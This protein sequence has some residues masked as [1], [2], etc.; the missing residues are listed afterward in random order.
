M[1]LTSRMSRAAGEAVGER[2]AGGQPSRTKAFFIASAAGIAT[3]TL[4]YKTLR[5]G[6]DEPDG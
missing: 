5:S 6:S 1:P 2:L 3:G 4:V